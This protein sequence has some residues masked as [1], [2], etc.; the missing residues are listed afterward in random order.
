MAKPVVEIE[1][2]IL[3]R[4]DD[5]EPG[6][7][8]KLHA[9]IRYNRSLFEAHRI[10]FRIAFVEWNPPA[11]RPLLAPDLVRRYPFLRALVVD[12]AVHESLCESADLQMMLNFAYNPALRTTASPFSLITS[13]DLFFGRALVQRIAKDALRQGCL[14]R[15]ERVNIDANLNVLEAGADDIEAPSA[16]VSVDT[17]SEPPYDTP[18]YSHAS[19]D[20]LMV[21]RATMQG[22]R[23]FDESIRFARLHLDSRFC[24]T[25]MAAGLDCELLG[26]IY[27]INHRNAY[28][29][30]LDDYPGRRYDYMADLP[31]VNPADWGLARFAWTQSDER[32][33]RI[34]VPA[35]ESWTSASL[36]RSDVPIADAVTRRL[37]DARAA[38]QPGRAERATWMRLHEQP[39]SQ[40]VV[41]PVWEGASTRAVDDGVVVTTVAAPWGYS[42]WLPL[43]G[44]Q[45]VAA[46][47]WAWVRVR[48]R[49][50][51]GSAAVGLLEG[52]TLLVQQILPRDAVADVWLPCASRGKP[53]II[54]RN[55]DNGSSSA[56]EVI[57]V[58]LVA[59]A[60]RPP[61]YRE[62][63]LDPDHAEQPA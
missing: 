56:I 14:Y 43:A 29:N 35:G 22:I 31:Y 2:V 6:W 16:V 7:T 49:V 24:F 37:L 26:R 18:P 23:G 39:L 41:Y 21:D 42:A 53:G 47:E 10:D 8:D 17:C 51:S 13:G 59:Q 45:T 11:G 34:G 62:F 44:L 4:N 9:S 40:I 60:R 57:D 33:W 32:L 61:R 19:G 15:A 38:A 36:P 27:H 55:G 1:A 58:A 50:T 46:D 52:D 28:T 12:P 3:G 63:L 48:A 30:R 54:F 5:Y 25:A 20:F